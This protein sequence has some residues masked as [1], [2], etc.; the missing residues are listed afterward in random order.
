[1]LQNRSGARLHG[2]QKSDNISQSASKDAC[3]KNDE[4]VSKRVRSGDAVSVPCLLFAALALF[5]VCSIA[6][7]SYKDRFPKVSSL[8]CTGTLASGLQQYSRQ[9]STL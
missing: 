6:F 2:H 3:A 7:I 5:F 8:L 4:D 1:M 9:R